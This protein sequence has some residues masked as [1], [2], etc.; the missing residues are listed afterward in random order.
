MAEESPSVR[1]DD[2]RQALGYVVEALAGYSQALLAYADGSGSSLR[3][4]REELVNGLEAFAQ[5]EREI[6][7]EAF[8][9][10]PLSDPVPAADRPP[11]RLFEL[12]GV[13]RFLLSDVDK[14][15]NLESDDCAGGP[16]RIEEAIVRRADAWFMPQ[17]L[18]G[19]GASPVY[20]NLACV[21]IASEYSVF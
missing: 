13:W 19:A 6:C 16:P 7:K 18:F 14:V 12:H 1:N 20:S 3:E 8:I 4:A 17:T 11:G 2:V 9:L 15:M 10:H 21:E 5:V